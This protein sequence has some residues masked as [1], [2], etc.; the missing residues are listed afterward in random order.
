M[1][2][3]SDIQISLTQIERVDCRGQIVQRKEQVV[4]SEEELTTLRRFFFVIDQ[5]IYFQR[6][7]Y[8]GNVSQQARSLS[9]QAI[10]S[11]QTSSTGVQLDLTSSELPK[12]I[13]QK[14]KEDSVKKI[15]F[16]AKTENVPDNYVLQ[17]YDDE[18]DSDR[19]VCTSYTRYEICY[20]SEE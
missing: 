4:L 2:P 20:C 5:F 10:L 7:K 6:F 11:T 17:M 3:E 19:N 18:D 1:T 15:M 9:S 16:H 12:E 14:V 13:Q 8:I